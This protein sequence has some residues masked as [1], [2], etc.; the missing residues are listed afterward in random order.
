M[1]KKTLKQCNK[2]IGKI[3]DAMID[4]SR[5]NLQVK[6]RQYARSGQVDRLGQFDKAA[7]LQ[8]CNPGQA[9]YGM[10][11]KHLTTLSDYVNDPAGVSLGQ[12]EEKIGDSITYLL[13]LMAIEIT[14]FEPE[15]AD[16]NE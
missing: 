16:E 14:R 4:L 9:C 13:L 11:A 3:I 15:G 5:A 7:S 8:G 12:W 6:G 1:A 10:M 2:R